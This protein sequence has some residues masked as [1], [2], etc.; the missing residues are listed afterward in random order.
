LPFKTS[1]AHPRGTH[2]EGPGTAPRPFR[3]AAAIACTDSRAPSGC[4]MTEGTTRV[5]FTDVEVLDVGS[6]LLTCRVSDQIVFV[7]PIHVLPGTTPGG[8]A[9]E[10]RW[11]WHGSSLASSGWS[12]AHRD[13]PTVRVLSVNSR[14]LL[15]TATKGAPASS[16]KLSAVTGAS[17][18]L[19]PPSAD[20]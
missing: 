15:P 18:S 1:H 11:C 12:S 16:V 3:R 7:P 19:L 9:T 13:T 10:G 20:S 4:S 17:R 8:P 6:L 2:P 14:R 5:E